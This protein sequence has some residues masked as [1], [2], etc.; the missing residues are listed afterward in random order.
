[1]NATD[2]LLYGHR[3]LLQALDRVAPHEWQVGGACGRWSV[4][5][6]IA[7]LASYELWQQDVLAQAAGQ[8]SSGRLQAYLDAGDG[9][10]D[11]EVE[12][13]QD[14]PPQAILA[15]YRQAHSE[16]YRLAGEVAVER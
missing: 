5:D 15:E 1:M 16:C 14:F 9:F 13:R 6:I 10:N 4:K 3:T 11:Q 2:I 8:P 7:H 12:R